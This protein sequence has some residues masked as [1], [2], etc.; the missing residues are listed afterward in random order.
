MDRLSR[1][2]N[3]R[4]WQ[5]NGKPKTKYYNVIRMF[6]DK[7][8]GTAVRLAFKESAGR[9]RCYASHKRQLQDRI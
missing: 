7:V 8:T 4:S 9:N 2:L 1:V 6:A 5:R 3:L